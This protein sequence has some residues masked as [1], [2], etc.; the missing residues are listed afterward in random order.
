MVVV[1]V[2]ST[3]IESLAELESLEPAWWD[4]C[5]RAS[6][7]E[8]V[9]TPT[10]LLAWWR[11]FGDDTRR[12][13]SLAIWEGDRLIGLAPIQER[14]VRHR[15]IVPM[16]RLELLAT[17]EDEAEE[18]CSDYVGVIAE[19]GAEQVVASTVA[20]ALAQTVSS[21]DELYFTQMDGESKVLTA[22]E[23]ALAPHGIIVTERPRGVCPHIVLP[24]SW[25][26][27][28]QGLD[29]KGRYLVTRALRELDKWAGKDGWKLRRATNP[30]ELVEARDVLHRLH[31]TRWTVEGHDGVF[32]RD[33]FRMFHD[34]VMPKLLERGELDVIWLE[35]RGQPVSVLYNIVYDKKVY[36]YQSG[37]VTK[38]LPKN[39]RV[40]IA[41]NCVALRDYIEKGY[42]EYDFLNGMSQYKRQMCAGQSRPIVTVRAASPAPRG[43]TL[44]LAR[45]ATER[46]VPLAKLLRSKFRNMRGAPA[47]TDPPNTN[48]RSQDGDG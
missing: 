8:P 1:T 37:R 32:A 34:D 25:D 42:R 26:D 6:D 48:D 29:S 14:W 13:R 33:R 18:I 3:R 12:L 43:Q 11:T 9:A 44:E 7:R 28:V 31:E 23:H 47:Q 21:W 16:R 38:D 19:R 22:L 24:K 20:E 15:G 27:Y 10:W 35:V 17:G 4:L 45:R 39:L 46:A 41:M 2:R 40:G 36:V 5:E 30:E